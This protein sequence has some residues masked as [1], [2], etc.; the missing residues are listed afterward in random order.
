MKPSGE[1]N[2][3]RRLRIFSGTVPIP[4]G[5]ESLENWK[6]QAII[7]KEHKKVN[8]VSHWKM[9]HDLKSLRFFLGF[10]GFYRC[11]IKNYSAIVRPLTDLT[12]G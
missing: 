8:A 4:I 3:Y 1:T 9:P 12:K 2:A 10:C 6:E 5:E 11:F 7:D